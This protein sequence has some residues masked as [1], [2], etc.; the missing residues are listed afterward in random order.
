MRTDDGVR[1]GAAPVAPGNGLRILLVDDDPEDAEL[2][3]AALEDARPAV[4]F[5]LRRAS[6]VAEALAVLA[7]APADAVLLDLNLADSRGTRTVQALHTAHP[8]LPIVVLTGSRTSLPDALD[9]LAAGAD[10]FL[11]KADL[12]PDTL[13]RSVR[14]AVER[15]R[16][17][18]RAEAQRQRLELLA[19]RLSDGV[20]EF[21]PGRGI[22]Y[23]NPALAEVVGVPLADLT[24]EPMVVWEA[25]Y[26]PDRERMLSA[27]RE[28]GDVHEVLRYRRRGR[29]VW[30]E[31]AAFRFEEEDTPVWLG[32]V[33]DVTTERVR[34]EMLRS[35]LEAERRA[36]AELRRVTELKDGF[37]VALA[38][39]LRTPLTVVLG[40]AHTL[41]RH[42]DELDRARRSELAAGLVRGAQRLQELVE[43]LG[44][45]SGALPR[46]ELRPEDL[47]ALVERVVAQVPLGTRR[48]S[49]ERPRAVH[50]LVDPARF[51]R[52]VEEL[53]R[54]VARHTPPGTRVWVRTVT[55]D[56]GARVEVEDDGPGIPEEL[57]EA[58]FEP[59]RHGP[60]ATHDPSP[61][62]GLGLAVVAR[63]VAA[64]GG[65]VW[66]E[67]RPEGGTRVVI[68]LPSVAAPPGHDPEQGLGTRGDLASEEE[69]R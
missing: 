56:D 15:R 51:A 45:V 32:T 10:D 55:T 11:S 69:R 38:H 34:E 63:I 46:L 33:R 12:D 42:G 43:D 53:L 26:P 17:E 22:T 28:R 21:R 35:A 14:Y 5:D 57:H 59:F 49:V 7:V 18:R 52:V 30:L 68:A 31:V 41:L 13:L 4:A 3:A 16:S 61:G 27:A 2:A 6:S 67:P 23:A 24:T 54:N 47:G 48:V 37:L 50:A 60:A 25:I 62:F 36:S 19:E 8:D 9:A 58:V 64:H 65:R 1:S 44:V 29:W 66:I 40:V 39:G 20:F